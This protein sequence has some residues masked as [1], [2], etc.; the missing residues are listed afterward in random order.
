MA[1]PLKNYFGPEEPA[2]I[3]DM[4]Q[5]VDGAFPRGAFLDDA[6]DGFESWS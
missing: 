1:E 4:I 3:A 2:R 5:N 6:L